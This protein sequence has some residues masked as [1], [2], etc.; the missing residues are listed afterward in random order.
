MDAASEITIASGGGTITFKGA[1]GDASL[2]K[3]GTITFEENAEA[4]GT[5]D[6]GNTEP[7]GQSRAGSIPWCTV[8]GAKSS[9]LWPTTTWPVDDT[10]LPATK[11]MQA[12]AE[13]ATHAASA[14][15]ATVLAFIGSKSTL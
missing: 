1:M 9:S 13:A 14:A 3:A 11:V 4:N 10:F 6:A 5:V 8:S 7:A 2:L 12:E 15:V